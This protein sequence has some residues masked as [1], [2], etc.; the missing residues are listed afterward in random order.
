MAVIFIDHLLLNGKNTP[1]G[2]AILLTAGRKFL[3][4]AESIFQ[5]SKKG[6]IKIMA[7]DLNLT[8]IS[9]PI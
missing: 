4:P 5:F 2:K 9:L 3:L 7:P 1:T 8:G 6:L